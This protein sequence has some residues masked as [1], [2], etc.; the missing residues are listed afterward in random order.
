MI[1][2]RLVIAAFGLL[3]L[4]AC[5]TQN[6]DPAPILQ[7]EGASQEQMPGLPTQK[8][9]PGEC[10]LFLWTQKQPRRF[11]YFAKANEPT[12]MLGVEDTPETM[13]QTSVSGGL[14]GQFM[15]E[16]VWM[17]PSG[18]SAQLTLVPGQPL[19]NGQRLR[20]AKLTLESPEGWE[21]IVPVLGLRACQP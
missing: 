1:A 13:R 4:S 2:S 7:G 3:A 20:S 16:Q 21:T 12:A 11:V 14:F 5:E 19:E 10:G 17:R 6:F 8:L 9:E 15:T 18:Q